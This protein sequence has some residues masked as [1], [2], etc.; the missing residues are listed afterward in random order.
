MSDKES[1][2]E[3]NL[4]KNCII[5]V[6]LIFFVISI[7]QPFFKVYFKKISNMTISRAYHKSIVLNDE[8]ILVIGGINSEDNEIF[9]LNSAE[10]YDKQTN[11]FKKIID[12]NLPHVYHSIFKLKNGNILIAD[13]NGIEIYDIKNKTFRLLNTKPTKRYMENN[14]YKFALF[15][16][17]YLAILGGRIKGNITPNG[18]SLINLN[19]AEIIDINNDKLIKKIDIEG[20][21]FGCGTLPNNDLIIIGGMNSK[22]GKDLLLDTIFVLNHKNLT[23]KKWGNIPEPIVNPF[24]FTNQNEIILIGGQ[25][26]DYYKKEYKDNYDYLYTKGNDKIYFIDIKNK[27]INKKDIKNHLKDSIQN[28]I[29]DIVKYNNIVLLQLKNQKHTNFKLIDL[30]SLKE[31][32]I[33][34]DF[35][36]HRLFRSSNTTTNNGFLISGGKIAYKEKSEFG[37]YDTQKPYASEQYNV[38]SQGFIVDNVIE[39]KVTK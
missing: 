28:T 17:D 4:K 32:K 31:L 21:G 12:T 13:I 5:L 27:K 25:I 18:R 37:F 29:L 20:N 36:T 9:G 15:G 35:K 8:N 10:M 26:F 11:K 1:I 34:Y 23:L 33:K 3:Q 19:K 38:S 6:F 2:K 39:I 16:N 7:H 30:V 24:V 14:N 22:E